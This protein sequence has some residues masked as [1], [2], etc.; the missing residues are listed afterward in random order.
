VIDN[1]FLS[2]LLPYITSGLESSA[3]TDYR[4]AT[5]MIV[6]ALASKANLEKSFVRG[7]LLFGTMCKAM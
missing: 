3:S 2:Q 6:S 7:G 1:T 5:L 4:A